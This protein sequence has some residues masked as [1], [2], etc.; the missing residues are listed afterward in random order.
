MSLVPISLA[1]FIAVY[2][3]ADRYNRHPFGVTSCLA[4]ILIVVM[5][6][7]VVAEIEPLQIALVSISIEISFIVLLLAA[8]NREKLDW[9]QGVSGM[10]TSIDTYLR[11]Q[12]QLTSELLESI[13]DEN[14]R[15][16]YLQGCIDKLCDRPAR[17]DVP[18]TQVEE[19]QL[20]YRNASIDTLRA[21]TK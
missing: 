19:Y 4:L 1:L 13:R 9:T 7:M 18:E 11:A 10:L 6:A 16:Y 20:G 14:L 2:M 12:R 15:D 8:G 3:L 21:R 5:P 17:T